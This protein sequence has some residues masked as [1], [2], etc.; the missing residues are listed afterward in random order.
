MNNQNALY[1]C[2]PYEDDYPR[3]RRDLVIDV[4]MGVGP[5]GPR[6]EQGEKGDPPV[7]GEDYWTEEDKAEII[8]T[9]ETDVAGDVESAV[10]RAVA[11]K[12]AAETAKTEA[13]TAQVIAA[14]WAASATTKAGEAAASAATAVAYCNSAETFKNLAQAAKTAAESAK[15]AVEGYIEDAEQ[16]ATAAISASEDAGVYAL[17]A[18]MSDSN[19]TN[20]SIPA[21]EA[22]MADTEDIRDE[23]EEHRDNAINAAAHAEQYAEA[24]AGHLAD[25]VANAGLAYQY[26]ENAAGSANDAQEAAETA[27][28]SA[29][30]AQESANAAEASAVDAQE[31]AAKIT[32]LTA[33]AETLTP[34]SE[35]T[36]DYDADTGVMSFGIPAGEPG[37]S[38]YSPEASV[39]QT[40]DGAVITVTDQSG[41][42]TATVSDSKTWDNINADVAS[43]TP[44][45]VIPCDDSGTVYDGI[46]SK[47]G[48]VLYINGTIAS[49]DVRICLYG[50]LKVTRQSPAYSTHPDWYG[51]PFDGF[52]IGHTYAF[53]PEILSGTAEYTGGSDRLVLRQKDDTYKTI[54]TDNTLTCTVLPESIFVMLQ[55]GTYINVKLYLHIV[56]VTAS[57]VTDVQ[58]DSSSVVSDGVANVPIASANTP[59]VVKIGTGLAVNSSDVLYVRTPTDANV[60]A[61]TSAQHSI[62]PE[63]QHAAT[64]YG[65]A[66]AAGDTS[67]S[68]SENAVGAYTDEA[69]KAIKKMLGIYEAPWEL[70]REDTVTNDT[71]ADIIINADS[72]G[73]AFEL[74]DVRLVLVSP[75]QD[76]AFSKA[77]YGRVRFYYQTGAY[78]ITFISAYTQA[79]GASAKVSYISFEQRD[80]MLTKVAMP[81]TIRSGMGPWQTYANEVGEG[82]FVLLDTPRIYSRVNITKVTGTAHYIL[83]GK[84]KVV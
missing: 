8:S 66:K 37:P 39:I 35:A 49:N 70:I 68:A 30:D 71:E 32:G 43:Y 10:E 84:R 79:T 23:A 18:Q 56:D 61:G 2:E 59:G 58:V 34:G 72:N 64:F 82:C 52:I 20:N 67:Q 14:D 45:V 63:K 24:A 78:D 26:M 51:D 57:P 22:I 11:A 27:A 47:R 31:A 53:R 7:R 4:R 28:A 62:T 69:R 74:T 48:R 40:A 76:T 83:Y 17:S 33:E 77:D 25:V 21:I 44:Q 9:V 6:G 65:L 55:A 15:T 41:T 42:T 1:N 19:I 54:Y 38:G 50:S 16:Y 3:M 29:S 13:Q 73:Q 81:N 12:D 60:K 75:Q 36:V 80:G 46:I 5:Q